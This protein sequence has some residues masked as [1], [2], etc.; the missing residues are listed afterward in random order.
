[1]K[2]CKQ[3]HTALESPESLAKAPRLQSAILVPPGEPLLRAAIAETLQ[4]PPARRGA[5]FSLRSREI[6]A[7]IANNHPDQP[8]TC[9]VY[10]GTDG[11]HIFRGGV[12]HS[13]VIDPDGRLWRGRSYEDFQTTYDITPADCT[14]ATLTPLYAQ[15]RQYLTRGPLGGSPSPS[16]T[17][18][19]A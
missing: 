4:T 1:M 12:G 17:L 9:T 15:M 13:L 2:N 10:R 3:R 16:G 8:W 18:S 19:S 7:F 5:L 6:Q 14:I 11:S